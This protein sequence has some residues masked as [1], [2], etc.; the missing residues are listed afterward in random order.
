VAECVNTIENLTGGVQRVGSLLDI[1]DLTHKS[2]SRAS[3]YKD[4]ASFSRV[5]SLADLHFA[6]VSSL[7]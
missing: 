1:R 7:I 5:G 6:F 3:S 2:I 4:L